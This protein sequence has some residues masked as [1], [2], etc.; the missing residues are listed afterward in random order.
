MESIHIGN[1]RQLF[2]DS[3]LIDSLSD[4]RLV[5]HQPARCEP[6][7]EIDK[8]WEVGGVAYAVL[9]KD[10]GV[11]RAWCSLKTTGS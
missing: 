6:I 11:F 10:D 7:I 3:H 4:A 8:P 2:V 9:C 1:T 5:L